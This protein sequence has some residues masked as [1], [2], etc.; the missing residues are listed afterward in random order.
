MLTRSLLT[1]VL[2]TILSAFG[3]RV[4]AQGVTTASIS[5]TVT[6]ASGQPLPG[7]TVVAVH[8]PSGTQYATATLGTGKYNFPNAR[9]GGPY[10]ITAT[11]VGY[12]EQKRE[13][14]QLALGQSYTF[15][16][17]LSESNVQLSEVVVTGTTDPVLNADRTGAATNISQEQFERLPTVT[18]N[19]QDFAALTPQAGSGF[20]FG[21]R[22]NLYNN[23]TIDGATSNNV[24]G[25]SAV[26]GG[27][28]SAQPISVDAIQQITVAIAPYDV[29]QGSFTGAGV[30]AVTRSGT[31]EFEGSAYVFYRNQSLVGKK[32]AGVE[33]P[34]QD[35]NLVNTGFRLGGPIV[36]NKL[37]FFTNFEYERQINPAVLFPADASGNQATSGDDPATGLGG[38]RDFLINP[39]VN[40]TWTFDPGTFGNFDVP[41]QSLKYLAKIDWN[42]SQAHRLSLRYNQLNSFRDV[43]ISNSGGIGSSPPG[44][45][46]NSV[47]ALPFSNSWYRQNQNLY[48]IIGELNSTFGNRFANSLTVGYSA[49][50]DFREQGGGGAPANFPTVDIL[51]PTGN[52]LTSFGPDPFTPNNLLDQD[53]VQVNDNFTIYSGQHTF[54]LG[55]ANEFFRF[56]NVFTQL[57]NGI[58]QY[59]SIQNFRDNVTNPTPA[60]GPV[61]YTLQYNVPGQNPGAAWSASQL[62]FYV[63]DEWAGLKNVKI[64]AG[65]RVDVPVFNTSLQG[66]PE[67]DNYTF[68]NGERVLV[69][70]LPKTTP[71]WSPR[72]GFNW[73]V[74]GDRR[75]QLRGG[76]G[77]F[78]GRIPFVWVSNQVT[79][80]G[81]RF[82]SVIATG[83]QASG[84]AFN[85]DPLAYAGTGG[86]G[87]QFA[88]NATVNNFRFPQV[89]RSN[90]AIDQQL[91]GGIIATLEGIYSKDINGVFIR[92]A[93]LE[94]P[95]GIVEGDGR[96]RYGATQADRRVN[97]LVTQALVLDNTSQ[98]Y[99]WS[100]TGQ[101]QKSFAN[102]LIASAAYT[103][104][105]ARDINAQSAST[106]GSLYTGNPYVTDVNAPA[107]SFASNLLKHRVIAN[108]SYRKEYLKNFAT[109]L[110]VIY[111]GRSGTNFSYV[112]NCDYNNDGVASDLIYIPRSR[113]E[114]V[115][116]TTNP[117]DT[118]T[119]DQIWQQLDSYI[120]QDKYLSGRRGQYA[121]R[122]G[123]VAPWVNVLNLRVLQDLFVDV[124]GKRNT[125]Q[126]S[127]EVTNFLNLLNSDWG[128]VQNPARTG[129]INFLGY[130]NPA[131][132][133]SNANATNPTLPN[134]STTTTPASGRPVLSFAP[135]LNSTF[136]NFTGLTSRWQMQVGLRYI[137]N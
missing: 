48:S 71:L 122:N 58:Y 134:T 46:Q 60:N 77:I 76:T 38:L 120:A 59:S 19:F 102:G 5:G 70:Q 127:W 81:I 26:P 32:I 107:L 91:P 104:T 50:R 126:L 49:F 78:T 94:A 129:L 55:T 44:N 111:E 113:E 29:R 16:F 8:T 40:K 101:L 82:G 99:A 119:T 80:N 92:D 9:I 123:G 84:F 43:P 47:T 68:A 24:F 36:K 125:L 89:F 39:G 52:V 106:A 28:T 27:Q 130:E 88:L 133:T 112:Y 98:G 45:R 35:F 124:A 41:T 13:G 95:I 6:D 65:V 118:R 67:A 64:T 33:Q 42:I 115:L 93:N 53:I 1:W 11:F 62:G 105:D 12:Q 90:F 73:D 103:Y 3:A 83:N 10:T 22:S 61:Q 23:F 114:V 86:G 63:Q 66:N 14:V 30:N 57:V 85:P 136:V 87:Q 34:V 110:S 121:E 75:T 96:P 15:D 74:T 17:T 69:G 25:L 132:T 31:N 54:V 72:V 51:G 20:N 21:G 100:I 135:G 2:I 131:A 109:T 18:R 137:F 116:A 7:A 37:F 4:M 79:N 117:A 128:L 97:D 108:A 56:N